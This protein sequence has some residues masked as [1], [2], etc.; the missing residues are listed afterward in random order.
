M[1]AAR[2]WT[3]GVCWE[4]SRKYRRQLWNRGYHSTMSNCVFCGRDSGRYWEKWGDW[5]DCEDGPAWLLNAM[6]RFKGLFGKV[7]CFSSVVGVS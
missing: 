5:K 2:A 6:S 7:L 1:N 3:G 4:T